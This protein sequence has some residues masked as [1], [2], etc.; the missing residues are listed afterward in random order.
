LVDKTYFKVDYRL[1]R[2]TSEVNA[3]SIR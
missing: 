2:L 1:R 3:K